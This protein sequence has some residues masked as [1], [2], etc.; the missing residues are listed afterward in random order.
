MLSDTEVEA[1]LSP[2]GITL[3]GEALGMI[4]MEDLKI[5]LQLKDGT[6]MSTL[7]GFIQ[8]HNDLVKWISSK[9]IR[10]EDVSNLVIN[11]QK[12]NLEE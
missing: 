10:V 9:T 1:T 8:L 12:V 4:R 11:G 2:I 5:E 6:K 7:T 3:T